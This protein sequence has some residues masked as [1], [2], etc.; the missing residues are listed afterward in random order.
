MSL[1]NH[2]PSLMWHA[3]IFGVILVLCVVA[4][5]MFRYITAHLPPPYQT[6]SP[7]PQV[8]PWLEQTQESL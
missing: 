4:L 7:A 8:T 3:K 2:P 5:F 1:N 6:K